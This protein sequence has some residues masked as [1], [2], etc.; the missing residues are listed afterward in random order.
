[1]T[2]MGFHCLVTTHFLRSNKAGVNFLTD[3]EEWIVWSICTID[4]SIVPPSF[5][6]SKMF[7][8]KGQKHFCYA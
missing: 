1:M 3:K 2:I 4:F 5:G 7:I 8:S 6:D